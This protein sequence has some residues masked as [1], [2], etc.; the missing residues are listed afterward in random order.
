[1]KHFKHLK[2]GMSL[3]EVVAAIAILAVFGT[4]IF[5]MQQ[6]LFDRMMIAQKRFSASLR[7]QSEL[8]AYQKNILEEYF[9]NKGPVEKSFKE[10]V[11][12]FTHPD[13]T[14]KIMTKS[15]LVADIDQ[16]ESSSRLGDL[17]GRS[18]AKTEAFY[19]QSLIKKF[20]NL[21]LICVKA[22]ESVTKD[23]I[24]DYGSSYFFVYI[25]EVAKK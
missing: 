4:S 16:K 17:S 20:K 9:E 10:T 8:A 15:D 1:M 3:L 11:K 6:F 24:I 2:S 7:M 21:R 19:G 18:I 5:M 14:I 23:K 13:M 22:S 25:P 12:E